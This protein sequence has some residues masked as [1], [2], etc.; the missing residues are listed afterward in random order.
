MA[1]RRCS[2]LSN[3]RL[4]VLIAKFKA[5]KLAVFKPLKRVPKHSSIRTSLRTY[6]ALGP[7]RIRLLF[8]AECNTDNFWNLQTVAKMTR[9]RLR[10]NIA[11]GWDE[12]VDS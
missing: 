6:V 3:L 7:F 4:V 11:T 9:S 5:I 10:D 2:L 8:D 12:R 1:G